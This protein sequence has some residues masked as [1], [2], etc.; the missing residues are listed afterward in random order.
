MRLA[1]KPRRAFISSATFSQIAAFHSVPAA[2]AVL[3]CAASTPSKNRSPAPVGRS[4]APPPP[5]GLLPSA[6]DPGPETR[7]PVPAGTHAANAV[8]RWDSLPTLALPRL[9]KH[10]P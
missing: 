7:S 3:R 10:H 1:V 6:A 8:T 5:L 4:S 9:V 2:S